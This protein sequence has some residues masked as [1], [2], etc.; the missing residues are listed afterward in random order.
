MNFLKGTSTAVIFALILGLLVVALAPKV[1]Q[2]QKL[3]TRRVNLE[4]DLARL[5]KENQA[6]ET[7]LHLL[8]H[9]PVYLEKVAREKF[10]KA[11]QGEIVYKVV[12][13]G[14]DGK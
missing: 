8:L 9:D 6:L 3:E 4:E 12:R 11:K 14:Q 5:R 1:M 7:E 10:N 13:P 2:I